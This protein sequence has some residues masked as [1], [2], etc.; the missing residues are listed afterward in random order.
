MNKERLRE[1]ALS[2]AF[3]H[4]GVGAA[5]CSLFTV[6]VFTRYAGHQLDRGGLP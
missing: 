5:F 1:H 4:S 6:V 2:P 3:R